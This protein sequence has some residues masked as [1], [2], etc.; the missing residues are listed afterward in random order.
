MNRELQNKFSPATPCPTDP[1]QRAPGA[2]LLLDR[3]VGGEQHLAAQQAHPRPA[4]ST[5]DTKTASTNGSGKL[6]GA[7]TTDEADQK[8]AKQFPP[9]E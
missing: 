7:R 8:F 6:G 9:G 2:G 5:A 4:A 1:A 3:A